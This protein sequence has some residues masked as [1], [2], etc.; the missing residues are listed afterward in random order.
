MTDEPANQ[1]PLGRWW[2]RLSIVFVLTVLS[3]VAV[4]SVQVVRTASLE[5]IHSADAIVV[6]GAAEYSGRPSPVLRARLDHA[7]EV[8][9]RGVAPVVITTGGAA[10]DPT[11]SEG[12]VGRDYLM[13]HGVPERSLIAETQGRDT[14]ESAVRVAVIM[15]ANGLH[16]CIAVSDAYHVF[17]IRKLLEHE[18]IAPVYVAPRPDSRPHSLWQRQLAVLR[19]A[20]SYLLWRMGI[21]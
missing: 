13:R 2:F 15:R 11:F 14:A 20:T 3:F 16:N 1:H 4:T 19:E 18:G 21:T 17:R 5:E 9:H 7:L 10:S 12:G 6:F 8:F